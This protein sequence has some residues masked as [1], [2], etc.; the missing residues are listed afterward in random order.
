MN[1]LLGLV[2]HPVDHSLSPVM[3]QAALAHLNLAGDYRL[4]DLPAEHLERGV[5]DL[6]KQDFCGFNVTIPHKQA[7]YKLAGEL[8]PEAQQ[9]QAVNTIKISGDKSLQGHNTDL[10][11]FVTAV[12]E[13]M[14]YGTRGTVAC[15]MGAGGAARA[16]VWGLYKLGW[17]RIQIVARKVEAAQEIVSQVQAYLKDSGQEKSQP[18]LTISGID[19]AGLQ[20]MPDFLVNCTPLGLT[21]EELPDWT[22]ELLRWTN[23]YGA[24]F[25]MVYSRSEKPTPLI[26][27]CRRLRLN[28]LDGKSML[29]RQAAAAFE[30]WTGMPAPQAVMEQALQQELT[31]TVSSKTILEKA[32]TGRA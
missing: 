23:P 3:H 32:S 6:L 4:I 27:N 11:G 26:A 7:F 19:L 31:K 25:D 13:D 21:S 1:Y 30:Y 9:L 17:P 2:G 22:E 14:R 29:V 20:R 24:V 5:A 28:C 15:V 10:G 16:A 18:Y 8:S 12:Q